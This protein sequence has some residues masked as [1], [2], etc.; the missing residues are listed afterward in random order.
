MT[1][2]NSKSILLTKIEQAGNHPSSLTELLYQHPDIPKR[3]AQRWINQW[4]EEGKILATGNQRTKQYYANQESPVYQTSK[5]SIDS[6][7][8]LDYVNQPLINRKPVGYQREFL[9]D[10]QPNKTAYLSESIKRQLENMGTTHDH[11]LPAGTYGREILSRLMIDLSWASSHLEGNTY[12]LLDTRQLIENSHTPNGKTAFET[13]MILNHK[14]A[15]ELIIENAD[16]IGFDRFTLLNLHSAL[17]ENLLPNALD[18]GQVRQHSIGITQSAYMP[19]STPQQINELFDLVLLKANQINN[20]FE[21]AF[22][23]MVHLP[24]L[25]PFADVNKR[26]SRLAANMPFIRHNLCP[27]TFLGVSTEMYN[28]AILGIYELTRVELLR[29]LF[30][31]AYER[32]VHA[33]LTTKQELVEPNPFKLA[34][35]NEIK[36]IVRSAVLNYKQEPLLLIQQ[37][38]KK[39][40]SNI[41]DQPEVEAIIIAELSRLHEGVLARYGLR[42]S[43]LKKW[44]EHHTPK[45]N[46]NNTNNPNQ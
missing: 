4:L 1:H 17:S 31:T 37:E 18:E 7:E 25:Q 15:I 3:T 39:Q 41:S 29:D 6:K 26:T 13:Q 43:E 34:Y 33:Y 21:Q 22:F 8:I 44:E 24:Y 38:V 14:S 12:S 16:S 27:L 32:S 30:V 46:P 40:I 11:N 9:E 45:T 42:P 5:I 23:I 10:Y 19:L 20:P 35:R 28:K 36:N 2:K